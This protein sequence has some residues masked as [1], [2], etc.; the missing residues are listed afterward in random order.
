MYGREVVD[1]SRDMSIV[2][3]EINTLSNELIIDDNIKNKRLYYLGDALK[4]LAKCDAIYFCKGWQWAKGCM[5]EHEAAVL[6]K[7][8]MMYQTN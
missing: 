2:E 8:P 6:Y 4:K 7:I 5:I 3:D 1:I